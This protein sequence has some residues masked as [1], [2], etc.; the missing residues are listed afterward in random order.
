MALNW[1]SIGQELQGLEA[2]SNHFVS[3]LPKDHVDSKL[4]FIVLPIVL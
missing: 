2:I 1:H 4:P 3:G